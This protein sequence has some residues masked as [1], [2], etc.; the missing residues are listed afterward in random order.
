MSFAQQADG[1]YHYSP[2]P[3]EDLP[4]QIFRVADNCSDCGLC[5]KSCLFLKKHGTPYHISRRY[6]PSDPAF[7]KTA[8][9]CSLCGLC[10][11]VCPFGIDPPAMF[12]AMRRNYARE[13]YEAVASG[14][15]FLGYERR[16][17][18]RHLSYYALPEGC[19]TIFFPGCTLPGTRPG[20]TLDVYQH[21]RKTIPALGMVLDCCTKPSHDLGRE[22]Y[23][24]AMFGDMKY[25]LVRN[26]VRRVI[27]AC[28]NCYR[29]F[30]RYGAPMEVTTLYEMLLDRPLKMVPPPG[31]PMVTVHDPCV[32]RFD[33]GIQAA[34]RE[35]LVR[36]G[37]NLQEMP[38][39]GEQT[40]C[41]GQG[42]S[43]GCVAPD[44]ADAWKRLRLR[45]AAGRPIV[46]YC[47]GCAGYLGNG[48]RS[49]HILDLIAGTGMQPKS[50]QCAPLPRARRL[51][52]FPLTCF[53]RIRLKQ[54]VKG[55]IPAAVSRERTLHYRTCGGIKTA[56]SRNGLSF[57]I[58]LMIARSMGWKKGG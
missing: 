27:V 7:L 34:A 36:G 44:H 21:L 43:A 23:F 25:F 20:A 24:G 4:A 11:A 33:A 39:H 1:R 15:A 5:R 3:S 52:G 32:L 13:G 29:I 8:F 57:F 58:S 22:N 2:P 41:C 38:H 16:G 19:D 35:L 9:E 18:S 51:P 37:W 12:L 47:T 14:C 48:G 28:P 31:A 46:T 56:V 49:Y 30:S 45:E 53:N 50:G 17:T 55:G 26:G 40:I 10:A 54:K 6:A 42:A